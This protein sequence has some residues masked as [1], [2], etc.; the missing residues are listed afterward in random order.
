MQ[1]TDTFTLQEFLWRVTILFIGNVL[2]HYFIEW[3]KSFEPADIIR[4][5]FTSDY[6]LIVGVQASERT[7]NVVGYKV[8]AMD[9]GEISYIRW[10]NFD[11]YQ[12][13]S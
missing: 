3:R 9:S 1:M 8:Q 10:N 2:A 4:K 7:G 5:R 13:E 12:V 11:D 6:Y